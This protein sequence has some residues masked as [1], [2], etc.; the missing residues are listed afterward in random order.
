MPEEVCSPVSEPI[1]DPRSIPE[2]VIQS[3]SRVLRPAGWYASPPLQ[4][5]VDFSPAETIVWERFQGHLLGASATRQTRQ[6]AS[7]NV[8]S[9]VV[10]AELEGATPDPILSIKWDHDAATLY[11]VRYLL[12]EGWE[13]YEPTPGV[14]ASRPARQSVAELVAAVDIKAGASEG[15]LEAQIEQAVQLALTGVS[16]L[17]I[18]SVESPHPL[19]SYGWC[20]AGVHPDSVSGGE[21]DPLTLWQAELTA[22]SGDPAHVRPWLLEFVLRACKIEQI[23]PLADAMVVGIP[24]PAAGV[25]H[26]MRAVFHNVSLTP[27]T[28]FLSK[29]LHLI[30]SLAKPERLGVESAIDLV[31]YMLRHLVRHLTAYDLH[32]FHSFGANYPDAV[33]LDQLLRRIVNWTVSE[34]TRF[35]GMG[36]LAVLRRRA[37]RMGWIARTHYE[38][39]PVPDHPTSQ[40][41]NRRV[42]PGMVAIPEEQITRPQSRS[43]KLFL[44]QPTAPWFVG[45]AMTVL[46]DAFRDLE[47]PRERAELGRAAY[48]DRPF[49]VLKPAGAIDKTPLISTIAYSESIAAERWKNLQEQGFLRDRVWQPPPPVLV[50]GI[51]AVRYPTAPRP[52]VV[53]FAD[54]RLAAEDFCWLHTTPSSRRVL[55]EQLLPDTSD[56]SWREPGLL[57]RTADAQAVWRG[58]PF[59]SWFDREWREIARWALTMPLDRSG[60]ADYRE[61][62][63]LERLAMPLR[64]I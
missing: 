22:A 39:L 58:E 41:E 36:P 57:L 28:D 16:R 46:T 59:L 34:P 3:V 50:S 53:S 1:P 63:G 11:L 14:I 61:T 18:V 12:V 44:D 37:V 35:A 13:T 29:W 49:G 5:R 62:G 47:L 30:D 19:F 6:F 51:A 24:D 32:R 25:P 52:G 31:G 54:A 27:M 45:D 26:L 8:R 4:L 20:C 56:L 40:G 10:P 42:L 60:E 23:E 21:R 43:R 48:L 15:N 17:P 2:N 7:W 64:R 38:G 33:F 9:A 55:L